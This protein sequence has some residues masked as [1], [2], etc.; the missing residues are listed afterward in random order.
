MSE[1]SSS[2]FGHT[3]IGANRVHV[4]SRCG[5]WRGRL[6]WWNEAVARKDGRGAVRFTHLTVECDAELGHAG[7]NS[8]DAVVGYGGLG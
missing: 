1:N 7:R 2:A 4:G 3:L 6:L 8:D 5:G